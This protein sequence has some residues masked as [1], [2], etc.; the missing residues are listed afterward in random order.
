MLGNRYL[1][2]GNRF[3]ILTLLIIFLLIVGC[4]DT[5]EPIYEISSHSTSSQS[6]NQNESSDD[7]HSSESSNNNAL[8]NTV[9]S[10]QS[11]SETESSSSSFL[12]S[13]SLSSSSL[14]SSSSSIPHDENHD[15]NSDYLFNQQVV[16]TFNI[17]LDPDSLGFLDSDPRAE[18]YVQGDLVFEGDTISAVGVRYKGS[19]GAFGNCT[20]NGN[21]KKTCTKLS[22]KIKFSWGASSEDRRFYGQKKLMLHSMNNYTSYMKEKAAY[23]MI[24]KIGAPAPR[25]AYA[26]VLLNGKLNGLYLLIENY[27]SRMAKNGLEFFDNDGGNFYKETS[28]LMINGEPYPEYVWINSLRS[29]SSNPVVSGMALFAKEL[30]GASSATLKNVLEKWIDVESVVTSFMMSRAIGHTDGPWY[31]NI[32][33]STH[34]TWWYEVTV[35]EPGHTN[36]NYFMYEDITAKK[37]H[38]MMWDMDHTFNSLN[39]ESRTPLLGAAPLYPCD[40]TIKSLGMMCDVFTAGV[41]LFEDEYRVAVARYL[42][43][44]QPK[45]KTKIN[46]WSDLIHDAVVESH[47]AHNDAVDLSTWEAQ[48][49]TLKGKMDESRTMMEAFR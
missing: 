45:I 21:G 24:R 19:Q 3:H 8:S 31:W 38:Y 25:T 11:S 48:V 15:I 10:D 12:S 28:P 6:E 47:D 30:Q 17:L 26:R 49:T 33:R 5:I 36:H 14:A 29:N 23:W 16:Q 41:L 37:F 7:D 4:S 46:Q 2:K 42:D 40:I 32:N 43:E 34:P 18:D 20:E 1:P 13:S 9:S 39:A 27:D 35:P 44:I 22:M